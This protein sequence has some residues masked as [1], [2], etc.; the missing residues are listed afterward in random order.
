MNVRMTNNTF[1]IPYHFQF[2]AEGLAAT[3]QCP[4]EIK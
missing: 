2:E 3:E 1:A 4:R